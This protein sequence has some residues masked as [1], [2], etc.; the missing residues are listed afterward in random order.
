MIAF[1]AIANSFLNKKLYYLFIASIASSFAFMCK[2]PIAF[3]F[4]FSF[5]LIFL[6]N[7]ILKNKEQILKLIFIHIVSVIFII[8]PILIWIFLLLKEPNGQHLFNIWFW[9]NQVGRLSGSSTSL[10]HINTS[11]IYYIGPIL[12][13]TLPWTPL[14]IIG[15]IQ[16]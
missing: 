1:W 12:E 2:G 5:W 14:F 6:I 11:Y 7:Y 4:I 9:E 3:V 13:Y 10:G 15:L 8:T 16:S